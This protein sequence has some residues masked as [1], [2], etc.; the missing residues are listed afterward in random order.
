MTSA[1]GS[2]QANSGAAEDTYI[3]SAHGTASVDLSKALTGQAITSAQQSVT[4]SADDQTEALTG[5]A[6]TSA[7][8]S[9]V[10]TPTFELTGQSITTAQQSMG[11][12]GFREL[13]GQAV[14][15]SQGF[16]GVTLPPLTGQEITSG[17]GTMVPQNV[18]PGNLLLFNNLSTSS[19]GNVTAVNPTAEAA[20]TG[21][22]ITSAAGTLFG[23]VQEDRSAALTG[24]AITSGIGSL[25]ASVLNEETVLSLV[26]QSITSG[27]GSVEPPSS[28]VLIDDG[29]T[30]WTPDPGATSPWTTV[31]G[32]TTTWTP[33]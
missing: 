5:E 9:P 24:S 3:T 17:H 22:E 32:G 25:T 19:Q 4:V 16:F 14:T 15:V 23:D 1:Q 6:I 29:T 21:Q 20:L 28:W 33:E 26:G 18:A 27:Q 31:S 30:T 13:T 11:A 12:P 8:G 2:V 7:Q 10:T